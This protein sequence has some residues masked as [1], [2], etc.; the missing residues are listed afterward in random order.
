MVVSS[1][2]QPSALPARLGIFRS[3]RD[4][5][6]VHSSPH[7][8]ISRRH[9]VDGVTRPRSPGAAGRIYG[10][11]R[12][13]SHLP[14]LAL[15]FYLSAGG[16]RELEPLSCPSGSAASISPDLDDSHEQLFRASVGQSDLHDAEHGHTAQFGSRSTRH[17]RGSLSAVQRRRLLRHA[18]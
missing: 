14:R 18:L 3:D 8:P 17:L 15:A 4:D 9:S 2:K 5:Y 12:Y 10:T 1:Q 16:D 11:A 13:R 6:M 7:Y